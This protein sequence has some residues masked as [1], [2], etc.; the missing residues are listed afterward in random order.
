MSG[1]FTS[2]VSAALSNATNNVVAAPQVVEGK[3]KNT[4][5]PNLIFMIALVIFGVFIIYLITKCKKIDSSVADL[6]KKSR[7]SLREADVEGIVG[8]IL[9]QTEP[10]RE[11]NQVKIAQNVCDSS[12]GQLLHF[13]QQKGVV[14]FPPSQQ[15]QPELASSDKIEVITEKNTEETQVKKNSTTDEKNSQESTTTSENDAIY[16][17]DTDQPVRVKLP[18]I[19]A[20]PSETCSANTPCPIKN[21]SEASSISSASSTPDSKNASDSKNVS[22]GID[23]VNML[24][25]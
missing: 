8:H 7:S 1:K 23:F 25:N 17:S 22:N 20:E 11:A 14:N 3:V 6:Q 18:Q 12:I 16:D 19:P 4:K 5:N 21:P 13:L 24:K 10:M 2:Q 15:Q 9:K